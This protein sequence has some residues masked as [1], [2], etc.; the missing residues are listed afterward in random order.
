MARTQVVCLCQQYDLRAMLGDHASAFPDLEFVLPN[1][2]REPGLIR[3]AVAFRPLADAFDVYPNIQLVCSIGAGVDGLLRHKGLRDDIK[4]VRMI[5]PEQ[6]KM[7][8]GF[9]AW[10]VVGHHR[11][12][13][14]FAG[15]Q[16]DKTWKDGWG[17]TVPSTFPVAVLGYGAMGKAVGDALISMGYPVTGWAKSNRVENGVDVLSGPDGFRT[18][19]AKAKAIVAV[20][21]LTDGTRGIFNAKTF[22][23][24]REDA[25][26]VQLGRGEHLVEG[27]LTRALEMGRPSVVAM[28]VFET[29][30]LPKESPL[31]GHPDIRITPHIASDSDGFAIARSIALSIAAHSENRDIPGLVD[32]LKGY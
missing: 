10:H 32:R 30:P 8:A 31:W 22:S 6:A 20:L 16:A 21:P 27:D 25:I 7:M 18:V 29:E 4:V 1:E 11:K 17:N 9:A 2:V 13:S 26:L 19:L 3:Y 15:F 24:M 12:M 5:N 14:D 28:D 23:M